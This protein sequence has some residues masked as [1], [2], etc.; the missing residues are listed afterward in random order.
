MKT[1]ITK[2]LIQKVID[3]E[4][5]KILLN[6]ESSI[7]KD[8]AQVYRKHLEELA[9]EYGYNHCLS[10]RPYYLENDLREL[11]YRMHGDK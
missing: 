8:I 11:G 10:I 7:T 2:K 6:C 1:T 4:N 5:G 3:K 9:I